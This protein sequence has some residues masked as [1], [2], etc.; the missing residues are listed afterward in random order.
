MP[1]NFLGPGMGMPPEQDDPFGLI[2][3]SQSGAAPQPGD[4]AADNLVATEGEGEDGEPSWLDQFI[5]AL[6]PGLANIQVGGGGGG[7][8][9]GRGGVSITQAQNP[10]R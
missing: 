8:S 9:R 3:A 10:F 4:I 1:Q 6:M 2:A 5:E 7:Y